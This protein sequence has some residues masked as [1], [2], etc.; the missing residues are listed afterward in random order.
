MNEDTKRA[1]EIMSAVT[2]QVALG[3]MRA[4]PGDQ[5]AD[6]TYLLGVIETLD[7]F[8]RAGDKEATRRE[9]ITLGVLALQVSARRTPAEML[10]HADA[11]MKAGGTGLA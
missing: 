2:L 11:A 1:L 4:A 10:A 9:W 6:L 5:A 8:I 7:V 3:S